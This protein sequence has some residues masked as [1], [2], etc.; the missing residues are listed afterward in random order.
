MHLKVFVSPGEDSI[1]GR[2]IIGS[3]VI[4]DNNWHHIM[5]R[6]NKKSLDIWI[7]GNIEETGW[8]T[9]QNQ[10]TIN[11]SFPF[12]FLPTGTDEILFAGTRIDRNSIDY[13]TRTWI[14]N[15][16][17]YLLQNDLTDLALSSVYG[18]FQRFIR[19]ANFWEWL[20]SLGIYNV[21]QQIYVNF[22]NIISSNEFFL[23]NYNYITSSN[24]ELKKTFWT[25]K[26]GV[27]IASSVVSDISRPLLLTEKTRSNSLDFLINNVS[28]LISF[29]ETYSVDEIRT[30]LLSNTNLLTQWMTPRKV[31]TSHTRTIHN[32]YLSWNLNNSSEKFLPAWTYTPT[33]PIILVIR[34]NSNVTFNVS[35]P[36]KEY[37]YKQLLSEI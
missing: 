17:I 23:G 33:D 27:Q 5:I 9:L 4:N 30:R 12:N 20:Y 31:S 29:S 1:L 21:Q 22:D 15:P 8:Y 3:T 37:S 7:D 10:L 26:F 34:D 6:R 2:N 18:E 32:H 35:I 24:N 19:T 11:N 16:E 14:R 13:Y 36:I 25:T 28:N